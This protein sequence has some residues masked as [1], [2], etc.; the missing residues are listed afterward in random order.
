[1]PGSS[2]YF[3]GGVVAYAND[4]KITLAGVPG[5]LINQQGAVSR[6]VAESLAAGVRRRLNTD[7]A[8]SITGIAGPG[9]GTAQ[10]PVGLVFIGIA[11]AQAVRAYRF[12]FSGDRE[13]IRIRAVTMAME[14]LRQSLINKDLPR[15]HAS[16]R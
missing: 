6:V 13:A 1:V 15:L 2:Q 12:Q 9:G 7:F 3:R 11:Q 5:S 16:K 14:L 4:C 8:I 10:K